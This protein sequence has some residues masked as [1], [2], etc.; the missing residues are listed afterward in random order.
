MGGVGEVLYPRLVGCDEHS[1]KEGGVGGTNQ[2]YMAFTL[3]IKCIL[4]Y[5]Y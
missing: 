3:S 5:D 2:C 4:I 1:W